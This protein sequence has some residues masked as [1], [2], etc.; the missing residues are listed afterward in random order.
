VLAFVA[1]KIVLHQGLARLGRSTPPGTGRS[2]LLLRVFG[3]AG[4]ARA[5]AD[6]VGQA[7]RHAGPINMICG[8]DL[9]TALLDPDELMAFWSGKLRQGFVA[10]PADLQNRLLHLD[11]TRD[12]DGRHRVNEFFCHDNTWRATVRALAQ[13]SAVVLMDLRGFGKDNRGCDF[14][15]AMLLGEVPLVRVVLLVDG[16]TRRADLDAVLRAAWAKLPA[17][18]PNRELDEPLLQL[19]QVENS[20]TAL[21]PLLARLFAAAA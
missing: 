12:P 18:S 3:H 17:T 9:A 15:L 5:L 13:R 2:L 11:E 4:R 7:W 10:S 8:T 16:S 19:F 14:E 20:G 1:Y 21:R 6:E